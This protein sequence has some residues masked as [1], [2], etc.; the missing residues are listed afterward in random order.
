MSTPRTRITLAA[1][2][3]TFKADMARRDADPA[4][5]ARSKLA[6]KFG[7]LA[8]QSDQASAAIEPT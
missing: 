2:L 8:L 3:K 1:S 5:A 7:T 6:Q 4:T